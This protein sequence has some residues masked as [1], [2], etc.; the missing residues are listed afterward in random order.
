MCQ[1]RICHAYDWRFKRIFSLKLGLTR[2]LNFLK[3]NIAV[4]KIKRLTV[5]YT[6]Y[7]MLK[8]LKLS[9]ECI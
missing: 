1:I 6:G 4:V 8:C 2:N 3:Y 9:L 5:M 7:L